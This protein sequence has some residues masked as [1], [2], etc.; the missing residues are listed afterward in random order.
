MQS[1]LSFAAPSN[2]GDTIKALE[3]DSG[4]TSYLKTL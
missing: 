3:E 1:P 4:S 2:F